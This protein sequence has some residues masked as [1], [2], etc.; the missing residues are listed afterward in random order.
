MSLKAWTTL[1]SSVKFPGLI[2]GTWPRSRWPKGKAGHPTVCSTTRTIWYGTNIDKMKRLMG[3]EGCRAAASYSALSIRGRIPPTSSLRRPC[4][5]RRSKLSCGQSIISRSR[6]CWLMR[7]M[8][9]NLSLTDCSAPRISG[10]SFSLSP[11]Q[12]LK[13]IAHDRCRRCRRWNQFAVRAQVKSGDRMWGAPRNGTVI[14]V[15]LNESECERYP[16]CHYI[17]ATLQLLSAVFVV[18]PR[19]LHIPPQQVS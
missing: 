18:G 12:L 1:P 16:S 9:P 17:A 6:F 11:S 15:S 14:F 2:G 8:L 7:S 19:H 4:E 13:L 3:L 10:Y 5:F